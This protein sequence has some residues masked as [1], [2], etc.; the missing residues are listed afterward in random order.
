M[1][2]LY[3]GNGKLL[4]MK[5]IKWLI[6][7]ILA[8]SITASIYCLVVRNGFFVRNTLF[9]QCLFF[10]IILKNSKVTYWIGLL[11]CMYGLYDCFYITPR[12][13]MSTAMQ[14]TEPINYMFFGG[15]TRKWYRFFDLFPLFLY[16]IYP[17]FLVTR[18]GGAYYL[19]GSASR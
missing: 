11:A 3:L 4:I 13:A 10:Y 15:H 5:L 7:A 17:V 1:P 19:T 2:A 14:F 9:V 18:K 16:I 12:A 8:F 6:L